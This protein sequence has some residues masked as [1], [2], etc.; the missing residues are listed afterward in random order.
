MSASFGEIL[1]ESKGR[2]NGFD[3]LRIILATLVVISHVPMTT[4]GESS[5]GHQVQLSGFPRP[6]Y[7]LIVPMFFTLSGFLVAGSLARVKNMWEFC[8]LRVMRLVPALFFEVVLSALVIGPIL[9]DFSLREYFLDDKLFSYFLNILGD[10]HYELPGLFTTNPYP[11]RVNVQLWTIPS[12]LKCYI[13]LV[14]IALFRIN[15][16][17][18]LFL[19]ITILLLGGYAIHEMIYG[20][21]LLE[22][23]HGQVKGLVFFFI[24]GVLVHQFRY[25]IFMDR[26]LFWSCCALSYVLLLF[27]GGSYLACFP[28]AYATIF[29]G[30]T[31]FRKSL[32]TKTGDYSYGLYLYGFPVQQAVIHLFP[33]YRDWWFTF[34]VSMMI[35]GICAFFSWHLVESK[36]LARKRDILAVSDR[37][38]EIVLKPLAA[39]PE[40]HG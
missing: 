28:V 6:F 5:Y 34:P 35:G 17:K 22:P 26:K 1:D 2:T 10:I 4:Y 39:N 25:E 3:Y 33:D 38:R 21:N 37:M 36:V 8:T 14:A 9:T 19:G 24:C 30:L 16:N 27:H 18:N 15:R 40:S 23:A 20:M 13:F 29:I 7:A 11:S 12:E 31:N 32:L